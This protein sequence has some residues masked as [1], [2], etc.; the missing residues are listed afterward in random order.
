MQKKATYLGLALFFL[1]AAFP[2]LL[3][4]GY[5]LLYSLGL[6]GILGEG[7][8]PQIGVL[9]GAGAAID[10]YPHEPKTND[11]PFESPLQNLPNVILSP[12]LVLTSADVQTIL[13]AL[14]AGLKS[15]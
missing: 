4:I 3:G 14:D 5:A 2:L 8:T 9:F 15:V 1:L 13:T 10:V 11:E 7:F 12:S 6:T